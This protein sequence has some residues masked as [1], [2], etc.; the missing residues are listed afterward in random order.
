MTNRKEDV[1]YGRPP[2]RSRFSRAR[3][4]IPAADRSV[5]RSRQTSEMRSRR[6]LADLT[7]QL[8]NKRWCKNS[9]TTQLGEI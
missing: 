3:A 5:G 4:E 2:I 8:N 7:A 9:S 1:G 6:R